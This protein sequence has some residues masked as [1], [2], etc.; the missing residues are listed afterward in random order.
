MRS[1][2]PGNLMTELSLTTK[3]L[4][5][6][7]RCQVLCYRLTNIIYFSEFLLILGEARFQPDHPRVHLRKILRRFA[8]DIPAGG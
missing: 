2:S 4:L 8:M 1:R 5:S 7:N 6:T 3:K